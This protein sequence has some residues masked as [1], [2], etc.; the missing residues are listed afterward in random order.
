LKLNDLKEILDVITF[1]GSEDAEAIDVTHDSRQSGPG[2]VFA[3]ITGDKF[4]G[5]DYVRQALEMG[6]IG[7]ISERAMPPG[8]LA[9]WIQVPD[10]RRGLA[11]AAAAVHDWPSTKLKLVGI[12]GTN[13]KTTTTHLVDSIISRAEGLSAMLGTI[14]YSIGGD[15]TEA[16]HTTPEASDIQRFLSRAVSSGCRSAAMEISSHAIELMRANELNLAAAVFTNLTRDHLDYHKSMDAYFAAKSKLFDGRLGTAPLNSIINIDDEYGRKLAST[17]HGRL[18]T[19]GLQDADVRAASY[20]TS[21]AGLEIRVVTPRGSFEIKSSLVGRPHAYN[22]LAAT[23]AGIAL[24]FDTETIARGVADCRLVAGRFEQITGK[25]STAG[26]FRVVV[27]YAH[28]DDALLNVLTTAR[29]I[30]G[31][32]GRVITVFGC[33][34]DRDRTKRAPMGEIAGRLSD[35]VIVT[36]DNPRSEDPESILNE[37]E[38]GLKRSGRKYLKI[39]DRREAIFRA[40][41]EARS[42][43]LVLIAGKGHETYQIIGTKRTHFDDREVA[44]EAME[45]QASGNNATTRK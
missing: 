9:S 18:I 28:T 14:S 8:V 17:A 1:S 21:E 24:G 3:A 34:G 37:I 15:A 27:D 29:E 16:H 42:G 10:A 36:S 32:S 4:D 45:S 44:R 6:S 26:G 43:D 35:F 23:A 12:T 41:R 7:V 19:Y 30:A 11:R 13:G 39:Q 5:N 31:T 22:I 20:E 38:P 2:V 25:A 33:G 40:I